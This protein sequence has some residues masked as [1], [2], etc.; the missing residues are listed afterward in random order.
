MRAGLEAERAL[1]LGL[2]GYAV[3]LAGGTLVVHERIAVPRFN[4]V[5]VEPLSPL[6]VAGFFE[7]ALDH[8]FQR[9]IRP[10]FRVPLPV[11]SHV[12][13]T[14]RRLGFRPRPELLSL[15]GRATRR[16]A[17][18]PKRAPLR[19]G[20]SADTARLVPFWVSDREGPELASALEI[21]RH[22]PNPKESVVPVLAL[23]AAAPVAAALVYSPG[24]ETTLIF[25]VSTLPGARGRGVAT[26]MVRSILQ[27]SPAARTKNVVIFS[28]SARLE[29]RLL[30]IGFERWA[31]WRVYDLDPNSELSLPPTGPRTG[32]PTWRPP[33]RSP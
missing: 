3:H 14:L 10:S 28:E 5:Q 29:R 17:G 9:A 32:P 11:P 22:H 19:P 26:S 6:R 20:T 25:G 1:V 15:L 16:T 7:R 31:R 23:E 27:R 8:Y 2:G 4:F 30:A 18:T 24:E 12:G 33:R 21:L 13:A